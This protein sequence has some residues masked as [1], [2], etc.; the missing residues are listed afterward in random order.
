MAF[1]ERT[2]LV[3]GVSSSEGFRESEGET[4]REGAVGEGVARVNDA[5]RARFLPRGDVL[6]ADRE[7]E[8]KTAMLASLGT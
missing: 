8:R 1:L 5:E 2:T 7:A 6:T 3:Q 4:A